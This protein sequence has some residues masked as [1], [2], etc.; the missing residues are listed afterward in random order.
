MKK[1][2]KLDRFALNKSTIANLN[3]IVGG[4]TDAGK[5][6]NNCPLTKKP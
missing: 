1:K 5:Q 4:I 3:L 6:V 2:K